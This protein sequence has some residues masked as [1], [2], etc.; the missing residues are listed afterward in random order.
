MTDQDFLKLAITKGNEKDKPYNFG[1][2]IIKNGE[3]LGSDHA[4]VTEEH[5]PSA[6]S[7]VCAMRIAG[8]RL[9][10]WKLDG[11]TLYASHEPCAM[12]FACAA[13]AGVER[14]VFVTPAS[15]A[16]KDVPYEFKTPD[17]IKLS[18]DLLRP[19]KVEQLDLE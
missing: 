6:H 19:M 9:K 15:L 16:K 14:I 4:H 12:C 3:V 11:C 1:A 7:E 10:N 8:Q 5:D 13:W 2:V 17:I 18:Q